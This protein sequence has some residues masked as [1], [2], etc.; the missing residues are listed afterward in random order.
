MTPLAVLMLVAA[1]R[2]EIM[3][4]EKKVT[5]KKL[6]QWIL[7]C[8]WST[9]SELHNVALNFLETCAGFSPRAGGGL[10]VDFPQAAAGGWVRWRMRLWKL[11]IKI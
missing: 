2:R 4:W 10:Q 6:H 8:R 3:K 5:I 7:G 1:Q 9:E 11:F